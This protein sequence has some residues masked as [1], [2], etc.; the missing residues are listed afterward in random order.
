MLLFLVCD[1]FVELD[2]VVVVCS[3]MY[4]DWLSLVDFICDW[5]S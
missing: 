2:F 1:V 5:I 3:L 4:I